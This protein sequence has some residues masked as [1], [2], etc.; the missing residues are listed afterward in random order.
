ML[1]LSKKT[2]N[3]GLSLV[4][5]I[6]VMAIMMVLLGGGVVGLVLLTGAEAKQ[7]AKKFDSELNDVKTGNLAKASEVLELTFFDDTKVDETKGIDRPGYYV[8]K[9]SYTIM[10]TA[11]GSDIKVSLAGK[12]GSG[13]FLDREYS[14]LGNG[15]VEIQAVY[16]DGSTKDPTTDVIDIEFSRKDGSLQGDAEE[17]SYITFKSGSKTYAITFEKVTGT[18][19]FVDEDP[20]ASTP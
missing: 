4:E 11:A 13:N 15:R 6:V 17:L 20:G 5:L 19:K 18:H 12:D 2:D 16:S 10:N 3:R 7:A 9:D 8:I 1:M 14:Y